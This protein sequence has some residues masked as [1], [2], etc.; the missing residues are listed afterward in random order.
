MELEL[1]ELGIPEQAVILEPGSGAPHRGG[2]EAAVPAAAVPAAGHQAGLLE[3]AEVLAHRGEGHRERGGELADRVIPD[4]E[5]A[6]EAAAGGI[7]EGA[8]DRIEV[9]LLVNHMV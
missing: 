2:L 6:Q 4:P 3:D 1:V 8:E 5:P 7:G 9:G